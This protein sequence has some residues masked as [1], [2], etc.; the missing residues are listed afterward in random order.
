MCH[1]EL[2]IFPSSK[3]L[4]YN[5]ISNNLCAERKR[6]KVK[7]HPLAVTQIIVWCQKS[8]PLSLCILLSFVLQQ[9]TEEDCENISLQEFTG[10]NPGIFHRRGTNYNYCT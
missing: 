2:N 9:F 5:V 10:A 8:N 7:C 6:E 1:S 4:S 3:V